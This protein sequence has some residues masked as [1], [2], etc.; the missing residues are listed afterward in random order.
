MTQKLT[1]DTEFQVS[2]SIEIVVTTSEGLHVTTGR[3]SCREIEPELL[4]T[5]EDILGV[6]TDF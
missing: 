2:T 5:I 3:Q 6:A 1:A 4:D